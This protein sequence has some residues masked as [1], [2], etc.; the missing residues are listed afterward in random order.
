[1]ANDTPTLP[2]PALG[3]TRGRVREGL[4]AYLPRRI[5]LLLTGYPALRPA[6]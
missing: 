5:L 3:R 6:V 2:S 1:M 4:A